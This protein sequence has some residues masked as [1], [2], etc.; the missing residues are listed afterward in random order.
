VANWRQ[1]YAAALRSTNPDAFELIVDEASRAM[2][3]RSADLKSGPWGRQELQEI[4]LAAKSLPVLRAGW[5]ESQF[6]KFRPHSAKRIEGR[7]PAVVDD[8]PSRPSLRSRR[9]AC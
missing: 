6:G 7:S 3:L 2:K 1:L 9:L 8:S 5:E 4:A